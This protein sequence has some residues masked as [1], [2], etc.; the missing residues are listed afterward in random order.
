MA[1]YSQTVTRYNDRVIDV[2]EQIDGVAV[3]AASKVG[4][5]LG[6][7]LPDEVPGSDYIRKLPKPE[8]YVRLY[9]DLVERLVKTQKTFSLNMVKAFHPVTGKIWPAQVRKAA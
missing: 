4:E 1:T 5:W 3:N 8:E 6:D 2:V 9:F 7:I